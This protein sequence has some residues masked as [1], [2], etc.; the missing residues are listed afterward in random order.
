MN[1]NAKSIRPE[2]DKFKFNAYPFFDTFALSIPDFF[3]RQGDEEMRNVL[4]NAIAEKGIL[5][6]N[7]KK[8]VALMVNLADTSPKDFEDDTTKWLQ[9]QS[10]KIARL[11]P[12]FEGYG[13]RKK[14]I[15]GTVVGSMNYKSNAATFDLYN[16]WFAFAMADKQFI[17]TL[18]APYTEH[19]AWT[20]VFFL[21]IDTL[22]RMKKDGQAKE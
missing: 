14:E 19:E 18:S 21:I 11:T 3:Q 13:I 7:E 10:G 15:N 8:D 1:E 17:G 9:E 22:Q 20:Q 16:I 5:F 6:L 4:P 2:L 12:G